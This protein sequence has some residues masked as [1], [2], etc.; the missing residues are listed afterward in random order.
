MRRAA[1][2]DNN[3]CKPLSEAAIERTLT[4]FLALDGWRCIKT[5]PVSDR[6][7]GK[8]FGELGM[9]DCQY[10]RYLYGSHNN[11]NVNKCQCGMREGCACSE[12]IWIE[13]K[14]AKGKPKPHQLEWHRAERARGA[15]TLIA[16]VDFPASVDGF[17]EFY[18]KSGLLR[19][20]GL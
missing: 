17:M 3:Q 19:R 5:D 2:I 4:D 7:R 11:G 10:T 14:S 20:Q 16:G 13:W 6:Q 9:A 15:L 8:G 18:R 12:T 1:R